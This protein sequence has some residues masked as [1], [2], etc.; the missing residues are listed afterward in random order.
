M[1][2]STEVANWDAPKF[3]FCIGHQRSL[4][5]NDVNT[6]KNSLNNIENHVVLTVNVELFPKGKGGSLLQGAEVHLNTK[7]DCLTKL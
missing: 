2:N 6:A 4:V 1:I 3:V 7:S 5:R